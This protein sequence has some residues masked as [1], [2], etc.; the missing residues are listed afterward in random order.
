[1]FRIYCDPQRLWKRY[2]VEDLPFFWLLLKQKLGFYTSPRLE[3]V[4]MMGKPA[5]V[6]V[7][8]YQLLLKKRITTKV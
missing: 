6:K 1:M 5:N 8:S 2:L 4:D 3:A 7:P